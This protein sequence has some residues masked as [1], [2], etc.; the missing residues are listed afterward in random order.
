MEDVAGLATSCV[1][2]GGP[3]EVAVG[4]VLAGV[5][6]IWVSLEAAVDHGRRGV[7]VHFSRARPG[8]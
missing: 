7:D 6:W 3:R 8:W 5:V 4:I 2:A 1:A